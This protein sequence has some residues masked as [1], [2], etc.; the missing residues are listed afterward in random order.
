MNG[1]ERIKSQKQS[2]Q[3]YKEEYVTAL[4]SKIIRWEE[5]RDVEEVWGWMKWAMVI[6]AR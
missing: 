5:V 2:E 1:V 6:G 4:E 3:Q